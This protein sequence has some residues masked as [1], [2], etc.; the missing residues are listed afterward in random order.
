MWAY[1]ESKLFKWLQCGLLYKLLRGVDMRIID[2]LLGLC[3][4]VCTR[5][6]IAI[7]RYLC[8]EAT[9]C[10]TSVSRTSL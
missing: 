1:I 5:L 10:N 3:A 6:L 4:A 7:V 2:M 9:M 8:R